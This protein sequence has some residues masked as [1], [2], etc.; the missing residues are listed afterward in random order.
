VNRRRPYVGVSGIMTREEADMALAIWRDAWGPR[1]RSHDLMIGVL[2]SEKTLAGGVNKY[3]RRY[4]PIDSV[5]AIFGAAGD[6]LNLVHYASD[7]EPPVSVLRLLDDMSGRQCDGF[8][9][10]G[11]WPQ[12]KHL[13]SILDDTA[14]VVFQVRMPSSSEEYEK[15]DEAIARA[16]QPSAGNG[17]PA[18]TDLLIDGSCGN[19]RPID[20]YRA[21]GLLAEWGSRYR[22]PV[23]FGIA[24]G[25]C[26]ETLTPDIGDLLRLGISIDAEGRLRDDADGG[27][28]L[29]LGKMELYL[30]RAVELCCG[31]ERA[32]NPRLFRGRPLHAEPLHTEQM[33]ERAQRPLYAARPFSL[34][35]LL[36]DE[37]RAR[38]AT[39]SASVDVTQIAD[40]VKDRAQE[41]LGERPRDED[42][43]S[44]LDALV[45]RHD[46]VV[47]RRS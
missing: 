36:L 8:Q 3:P 17:P 35:D 18:F 37:L 12:G 19:G 14:R 47:S 1:S 4:P 31:N 34:S 41:E 38:G 43:A 13:A 26:A 15:T 39:G 9:F 10:N 28:S 5:A 32:P 6:V 16:M 23:R 42:I 44:A 40:S 21:G 33:P 11:A 30:R 29:D 20:R 27:G 2:V 7:S 25:L 46:V 22:H 24:G 45:E